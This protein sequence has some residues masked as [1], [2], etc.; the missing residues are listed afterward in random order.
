MKIIIFVLNIKIMIIMLCRI[1]KMAIK[2]RQNIVNL[3]IE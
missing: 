2:K 1:E 3:L